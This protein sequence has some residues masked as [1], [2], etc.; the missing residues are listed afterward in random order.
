MAE[1]VIKAKLRIQLLV[2]DK[3][4]AECEDAVLWQKVLRAVTSMPGET[5][6]PT[7]KPNISDELVEEE[8]DLLAGDEIEALA[9]DLGVSIEVLNG[10]CSPEK[11]SPYIHLDRHHWEA[12]KKNTP[13]RGPGGVGSLPFALTTLALWFN[14]AG[15]GNPTQ[16]QAR[17]VLNTIGLSDPN[18]ARGIK[19]TEWLQQRGDGI[20]LKPDAISKAIKVVAAYC[21][22]RPI[23]KQT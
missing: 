20:L 19:N 2:D 11:K 21:L 10:A 15:L 22:K 3:V 14:H 12:F 1:D 16:A 8:S 7:A 18:P 6:R 23:D 17:A 4:I 9:A 5:A 13:K